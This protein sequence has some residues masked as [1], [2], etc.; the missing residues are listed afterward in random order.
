MKKQP[1]NRMQF[2]TRE[3][4]HLTKVN[5][6]TPYI[7][8]VYCAFVKLKVQYIAMEYCKGGSLKEWI[9]KNGKLDE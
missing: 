8:E 5:D 1:S 2:A 9:R 4:D 3:I 7:V 6:K